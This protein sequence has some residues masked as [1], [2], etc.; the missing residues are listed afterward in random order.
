MK[1]LV[2]TFWAFMAV[3][4]GETQHPPEKFG[5]TEIE[6]IIILEADMLQNVTQPLFYGRYGRNV[7]VKKCT[8]KPIVHQCSYN[9]N[10]FN[11]E[12]T[13]I[14]GD[15]PF[16]AGIMRVTDFSNKPIQFCTGT[17][18]DES[19]VLTAAQ[20]IDSW[21]ARDVQRRLRVHLG[22]TYVNSN[23]E[24][25]GQSEHRVI[26][27]IKHGAYTIKTYN[28]DIAILTLE[29]PARISSTIKPICL[30]SF[31]DSYEGQLATVAAW[32]SG[33]TINGSSRFTI[34]QIKR[35]FG[36]RKTGIPVW[37]NSRC[38]SS[39]DHAK[40]QPTMICAADECKVD[41][42]GPLFMK[43][44][45]KFVQLGIASWSKGCALDPP[46]VFTRVT[47]AMDWIQRIRE[48]Y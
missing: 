42:G 40:V 10:M 16:L 1:L 32:G 33:A 35:V 19:H 45:S 30:P 4:H 2:L 34:A 21:S 5:E 13:S 8:P 15:Y 17:L 9:G 47:K 29:T 6:D 3:A 18:I 12:E 27:V 14:N 25:I 28:N 39:Y 31:H 36:S 44:G 23:K 22:T 20:C 37:T 41:A 26:R 24:V 48:C 11:G 38:A 43:R 7:K 46:G